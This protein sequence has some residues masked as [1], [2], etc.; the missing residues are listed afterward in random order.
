M[1]NLYPFNLIAA[2]AVLIQ[3]DTRFDTL[4]ALHVYLL[5][6]T[7]TYGY[8]GVVGTNDEG[9]DGIHA[10]VTLVGVEYARQ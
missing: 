3:S 9:A 4:D 7:C 10:V 2:L 5:L 8:L 1:T 6:D